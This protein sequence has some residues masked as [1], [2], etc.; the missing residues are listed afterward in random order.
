MLQIQNIGTQLSQHAKRMHKSPYI[1][2]FNLNFCLVKGRH[3][4]SNL[5]L[6]SRILEVHRPFRNVLKYTIKRGSMAGSVV[7]IPCTGSQSL[8]HKGALCA[9]DLSSSSLPQH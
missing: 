7:N 4:T 9:F 6:N 5:V 2:F 1:F 3:M 8:S